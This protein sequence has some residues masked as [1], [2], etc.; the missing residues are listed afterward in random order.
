MIF[1]TNITASGVRKEIACGEIKTKQCLVPHML[2]NSA[3]SA[4]QVKPW[5]T[6]AAGHKPI[7]YLEFILTRQSERPNKLFLGSARLPGCA[8]RGV[9]S[10]HLRGRRGI[11]LLV[12]QTVFIA[13]RPNSIYFT[14]ACT[15]EVVVKKKSNKGKY[16]VAHI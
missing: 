16:H 15:A 6:F 7:H 13:F 12:P 4:L 14:G 3:G 11:L 10:P 5:T 1:T 8:G 2:Q 9:F